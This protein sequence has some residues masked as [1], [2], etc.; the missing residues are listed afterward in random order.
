M[1]L[2]KDVI[3]RVP[4]DRPWFKIYEK[5]GI[6]KHIDIP[7]AS[8]PELLDRAAERWPDRPSLIF[9]GKRM[10]FK[11]LAVLTKKFAT[12][13]ADLG[14]KKG[15]VVALYLP[16]CPQFVIAYYGAMR[17]GADLAT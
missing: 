5:L 1:S 2:G 13:L 4:E 17:L 11:E 14:V 8:L 3:E 6:R 7:E 15:D 9:Y 16:N 12:A 10:T